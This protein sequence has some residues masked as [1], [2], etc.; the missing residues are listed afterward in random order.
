VRSREESLFSPPVGFFMIYVMVFMSK[1]L[2]FETSMGT[3]KKFTMSELLWFYC[4]S[5]FVIAIEKDSKSSY[6]IVV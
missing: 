4:I 6:V 1:H 3:G 5:C 2:V